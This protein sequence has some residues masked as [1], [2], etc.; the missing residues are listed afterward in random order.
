MK[1]AIGPELAAKLAINPNTIQKAYRDLESEGYIYTVT[2]K[3]TFVQSEKK[4]MMRGR[5]SY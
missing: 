3:G 5:K 4:F 1:T 2:G